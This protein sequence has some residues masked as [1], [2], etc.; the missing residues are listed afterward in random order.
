MHPPYCS[1]SFWY[2][3][4]VWLR[5]PG[6]RWRREIRRDWWRDERGQD[7]LSRV[8]RFSGVYTTFKTEWPDLVESVRLWWPLFVLVTKFICDQ[9]W[10]NLNKTQPGH[11]I[12][13]NS[14]ESG[15]S[16]FTWSP[17]WW[18]PPLRFSS[19]ELFV[20][21]LS[22]VLMDSELSFRLDLLTRFWSGDVP[23]LKDKNVF[24]QTKTFPLPWIDNER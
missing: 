2:D 3:S 10:R 1:P 4:S 17:V 24:F 11:S 14:P 22:P 8:T 7:P 19:C 9:I 18:S 15:H 16:I 6:L 23:K 13:T 21:D 12:D 5:C 20:G